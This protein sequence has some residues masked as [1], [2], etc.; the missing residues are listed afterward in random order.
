MINKQI[1]DIMRIYPGH[2][3]NSDKIEFVS[4]Q[5]FILAMASI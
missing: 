3:H 4:Q 2:H 5:T 1:L